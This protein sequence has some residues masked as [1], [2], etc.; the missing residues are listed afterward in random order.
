L[1]S[2]R[3]TAPA[4]ATRPGTAAPAATATAPPARSPAPAPLTRTRRWLNGLTLL[5]AHM[6]HAVH[7]GTI[8][9]DTLLQEARTLRRCLPELARLGRPA[10]QLR[11]L[12]HLARRACIDFKQAA[13]YAIAASRIPLFSIGK[14][15]A[16]NKLLGYSDK[17][18]NKGLD[19]IGRAVAYGSVMS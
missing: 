6:N 7:A 15:P 16:P 4:P 9:S 1:L 19:L 10:G 5:Q 11:P 17:Y 8:T 3:G 14:P 2:S 18:L 12:Y 13:R